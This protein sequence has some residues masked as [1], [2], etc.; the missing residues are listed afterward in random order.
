[1]NDASLTDK[2]PIH[3]ATFVEVG[4]NNRACLIGLLQSGEQVSFKI[5]PVFRWC[6]AEHLGTS[7]VHSVGPLQLQ[8]I[9]WTVNCAMTSEGNQRSHGMVGGLFLGR[10]SRIRR[11][12]AQDVADTTDSLRAVACIRFVRPWL[13]SWTHRVSCFSPTACLTGT[14]NSYVV[15]GMDFEARPRSTVTRAFPGTMFRGGA[16]SHRP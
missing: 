9:G 15:I 2:T 12:R 1:M 7:K 3:V 8:P 11:R 16:K 13:W 5:S 6:N 14:V 4:D 10:T